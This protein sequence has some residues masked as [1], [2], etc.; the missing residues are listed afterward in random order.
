MAMASA[1]SWDDEYSVGV[2]EIDAQ[3][4]A[5]FE[6]YNGLLAAYQ[7]DDQTIVSH[8]FEEMANYLDVHFSSEE[9]FW[10]LDEKLYREHRKL[11]FDFVKYVLKE[12]ADG[13]NLESLGSLLDFLAT[14]LFD[15][16]QTV[17]KIQ[18]QQLRDQGLL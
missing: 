11:H 1:I 15:H 12:T 10:R 6:L 5:L 13:S 8:A 16:V 9:E 14:W 4:K 18:F 7:A 2:A 3:H 17:D